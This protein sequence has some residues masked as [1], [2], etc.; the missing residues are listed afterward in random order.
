SIS[1][2]PGAIEFAGGGAD[3]LAQEGFGPDTQKPI[4]DDRATMIP[5][6]RGRGLGRVAQSRQFLTGQFTTIAF[7]KREANI[8]DRPSLTL[9]PFCCDEGITAIVTFSCINDALSRVRKELLDSPRYSSTRQIN[10]DLDLDSAT[11]G[12]FFR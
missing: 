12:R 8:V 10:Q 6:S 1:L 4:Q 11:E 5:L 3:R 9:Q 7:W 2:N